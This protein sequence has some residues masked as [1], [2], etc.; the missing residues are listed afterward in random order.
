MSVELA[1]R[2]IDRVL[3][4]GF[5]VTGRAV[6]ASCRAR[7]IFVSVSDAGRLSDEARGWLDARGIPFE[8]GGHTERFLPTADALVLSPGVCV[9][10]PVVCA[11][12]R[13]GLLDISELDLAF[14]LT[15]EI[16][17]VAV[18]GTNGKGTTV[19]L[20]DVLLREIGRSPCVGGNIG[21]PFVALLDRIPDCDV[22]VLEVSSFQAEQSRLLRPRVGVLLNLAPD[23]LDRHGSMAAYAAAK[24]RLFRL[25]TERDAAVLPFALRDAFSQGRGRRLY[26]DAP[27]PALP[28]GA[29]GLSSHNRAN[30]AA[31]VTA[32]AALGLRLESDSVPLAALS[33][34]FHLPHRMQA[35][36][37]IDGIRAI[38]DSKSTNADAAVAALRATDA[39]TVLLIGG[40]HKGAGYEA[41]A[42]E[43]GRR[44]VRAVVLFGEASADFEPLFAST[45]A[46][47]LR[48]DGLDDAVEE[49]LAVARAGD[50]LLF[51]PACA[52][53]DA[54]RNYAER[55]DAFARA[56]RGRP[57]FV[58]RS[59]KD[60]RA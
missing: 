16:P 10:D 12:R 19:T 3:V 51:S 49:G 50:V 18:T 27:P 38:D 4:L 14:A 20:I 47:V 31:A 32:I 33:E 17:I 25:Q 40:R 60:L 36:G 23:H 59:T 46:T 13:R 6:A 29:A 39:P 37:S 24:G 52:S 1:G 54:Y 53:F 5:G 35:I 34:A 41:L 48:A 26:F 21:T 2:S 44:D 22:V 43:I 58:P 9:D 57:G 45:P 8:E 56:V 30:L 15:G 11:A 55:G 7:D 28:D 42:A